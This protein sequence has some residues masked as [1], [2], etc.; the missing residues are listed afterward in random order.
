[1]LALPEEYGGI[2]ASP[3]VQLIFNE[4]AGYYKAPGVDVF[5]VKM[6][7]PV[8]HA[9]GNDEQKKEHL[10]KIARGEVFWC[11]GWSEPDAGSAGPGEP[12]TEGA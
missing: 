10:G 4:V 9:M 8:I 5:G 3:V 7:G 11:Q 2:N 6:I 1:M 12:A